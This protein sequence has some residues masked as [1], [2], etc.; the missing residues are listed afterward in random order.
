MT[1]LVLKNEGDNLMACQISSN[2]VNHSLSLFELVKAT[3]V[4]EMNYCK[5]KKNIGTPRIALNSAMLRVS[6][7]QIDEI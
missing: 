2:I 3:R 5:E 7:F 6:S 4:Q 1:S